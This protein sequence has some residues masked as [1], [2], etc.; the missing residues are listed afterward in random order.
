MA[1]LTEKE[2]SLA[3]LLY[4]PADAALVAEREVTKQKLTAYNRLNPLDI[5]ARTMAI[6]DLFGHAGQNCVVEQPLF[7]TYGSNTT[8]GDNFF[9]N[10]DCKLLDSGKITIGN[11]VFIAPNVCLI[12]EEH[13]LDVKQRLAGLEYTHPI[14]IED[15]VWIAAGVLVLPGVTIGANSVIGAGSVVTKDIPANSLAVGNPCRVLRQLN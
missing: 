12:T 8:V 7:C 13:A 15:N 11:N 14:T 10:V 9:L 2:K 3:E 6:A 4:Q 1:E 5:T